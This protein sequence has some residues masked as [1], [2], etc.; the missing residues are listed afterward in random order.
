MCKNWVSLSCIGYTPNELRL[1][2]VAHQIHKLELSFEGK[3]LPSVSLKSN[4]YS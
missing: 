3:T 1:C 4:S 2:K